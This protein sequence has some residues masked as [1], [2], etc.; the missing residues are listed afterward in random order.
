M[1][2]PDNMF[3]HEPYAPWHERGQ[4]SVLEV[5]GQPPDELNGARHRVCSSQFYRPE[6]PSR[7]NRFEGDGMVR[8]PLLREGR[9][10]YGGFTNGRGS[11]F[12]PGKFPKNPGNTQA[13]LYDS[14]L[15]VF[16]EGDV[17]HALLP[18]TY[19]YYSTTREAGD[20]F[21]DGLAQRNYVIGETSMQT[22]DGVLTSR[23]TRVRTPPC[24]QAEDDGWLLPIW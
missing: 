14:R 6:N 3:R 13:S 20:W 11:P 16:C 7:Y 19:G 4:A 10:T 12:P 2:D 21:T 8:G 1:W 5:E 17:P 9:A 18:D 23:R 15:L 22:L 24:T